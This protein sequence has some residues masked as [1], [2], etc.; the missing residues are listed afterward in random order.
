MRK[1]LFLGFLILLTSVT[2]VAF[3]HSYHYEIQVSNELNSSNGQLKELKMT[4]FYDEDVSNVMMQDQA[5][6]K[7][8]SSKLISDLDLLGYFTQLKINGKVVTLGKAKNV[9]LKKENNMLMLFFTL[10][11]KTPVAINKGSTLSLNHEDPGSI[12]ILYYEKPSEIIINGSLKRRCKSSVKEKG[13]FK[14][15]EFPQT[16]NI[17]C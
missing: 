5:D 11:L 13:D 7:K 16:V 14:E 10:P 12:A 3:S 15:G 1:I 9:Q 4:W 17:Y 8:L 2:R 6:L